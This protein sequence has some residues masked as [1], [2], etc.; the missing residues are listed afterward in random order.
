LLP[1]RRQRAEAAVL[2][3]LYGDGPGGEGEA[4]V[5]LIRRSAHLDRDPGHVALP[6]GFIEAGEDPLAAALREAEEEVGIDP[7]T[8]EILGRLDTV[9]RPRRRGSVVPFVGLLPGRP[10]LFPSPAE[11]EAILEV[12]LTYLVAEG[13][14]WEERW[15]LVEVPG[16][17]SPAHVV[18]FFAHEAA[19]GDDLVWGVT[20]RILWDLLERVAAARR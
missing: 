15:P 14:A 2:V 4:T 11:V 6:G 8:V 12:P 1:P 19:L 7:S 17:P 20:A 9:D 16:G 3:A 10:R 18:R 5:V 13:V